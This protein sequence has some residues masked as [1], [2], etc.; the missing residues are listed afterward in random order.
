[1]DYKLQLL[2]FLFSF[3]FG[4]FFQVTNYFNQKLIINRKILWQYL[5]TFLYI[6]NIVLIYIVL[7]YKINQ[8]VFHIYFLLM[9]LLGYLFSLKQIK[10]VKKCVKYMKSYIK[11]NKK[12]L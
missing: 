3:L 4:I 10:N 2:S 7:L 9:I 8:G 11:G 5:I 6:I 12:V 1:M